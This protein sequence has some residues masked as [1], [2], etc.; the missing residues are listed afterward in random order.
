MLQAILHVSLVMFS[1]RYF[2]NLLVAS[3]S[4]PMALHEGF[5]IGQMCLYFPPVFHFKVDH[6]Q[7]KLEH[8]AGPGTACVTHVGMGTTT[9]LG[10]NG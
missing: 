7:P 3:S 6:F 2:V 9:D 8:R 10:F 5:M 4:K 1:V